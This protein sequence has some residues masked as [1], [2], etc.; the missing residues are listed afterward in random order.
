MKHVLL[1]AGACCAA[2]MIALAAQ[3]REFA[4]DPEFQSGGRVSRLASALDSDRDGA[5]STAEMR[6]ASSALEVLDVNGDGQLTA[7]ELRRPFGP[8]GP[9]GRGDRERGGRGNDVETRGGAGEASTDEL[10]DTLMAFDRNGDAKLDR[11]E[12]P[13]RFQGLFDRADA[14]KDA[15]LTR[16]ELKQSAS[17]AVQEGGGRGRRGAEGGREFGRGRGRGGFLDPL[18]RAL[19]TDR[20]GAVS[21]AEIAGAADALKTLDTN[22]DGQLSGDE[23]RP[24]PPS[25]REGRR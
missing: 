3:S 13:E 4:Q 19:D 12:V 14:N 1:T 23:F 7:D 18:M 25:G 24:V 21:T 6:S 15:V 9:R 10:T 20:D 8:G 16:D 17:A 22:Q 11:A 5:I 2:V